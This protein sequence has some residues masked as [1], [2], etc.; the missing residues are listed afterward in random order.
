[1]KVKEKKKERKKKK[2]QKRTKKKK[3]GAPVRQAYVKVYGKSLV[4]NSEEFFKDGYT[5]MRGRFDYR[6]LSTDQLRQTRKLA[7]LVSTEDMGKRVLECDIPLSF[8]SQSF[9]PGLSS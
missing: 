1:M 8:I 6:T 3:T 4:D 9:L 5:D 7:I 2:I